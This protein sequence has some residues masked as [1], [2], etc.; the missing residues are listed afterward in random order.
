MAQN[1][2]YFADDRD[3]A[4]DVAGDPDASHAQLA[5][6]VLELLDREIG[7][8]QRDGRETDE[9]IRVGRAPLRQLLVLNG[10][11]SPRQLAVRA[12]PPAALVAQNLDVD[13]PFIQRAKAR[14][15][16]HQGSVQVV[17][18]V[19]G[20][21]RVADD[22]QLRRLDEVAVNVDDLDPA[23][24]DGHFASRRLPEHVRAGHERGGRRGPGERFDEASAVCHGVHRRVDNT[25]DPACQCRGHRP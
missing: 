8:L 7:M 22:V 6:G 17:A 12:V 9:A 16:E 21:V 11:D 10:D 19:A 1:G 14:R 13:A 5:D 4:G 20:E 23:S 2:S 3:L 18:D 15:T 25:A 24:P